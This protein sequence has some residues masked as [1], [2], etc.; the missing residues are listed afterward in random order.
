[1]IFYRKFFTNEQQTD[2]VNAAL[3]WF[4]NHQFKHE[5][6]KRLR[7]CWINNFKYVGNIINNKSKMRLRKIF[8]D[9]FGEQKLTQ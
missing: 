7:S 8:N 5:Y 3:Y 1:M 2:M 4:E 6:A 9:C